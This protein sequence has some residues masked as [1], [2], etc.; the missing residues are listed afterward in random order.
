LNFWK[1]AGDASRLWSQA[2]E[3][4][5]SEFCSGIQ[6]CE[7]SVVL[8]SQLSIDMDV[9]NFVGSV[10]IG[11]LLAWEFEVPLTATEVTS[12]SFPKPIL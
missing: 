12:I 8:D 10:M 11:V 5:C 9:E 4:S 1:L 2:D 7:D 6:S 3:V